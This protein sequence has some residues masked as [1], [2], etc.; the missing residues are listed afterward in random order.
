MKNVNPVAKFILKENV[1]LPLAAR[2]D[3]AI[4]NL[5]ACAQNSIAA[6]ADFAQAKIDLSSVLKAAAQKGIGVFRAVQAYAY[7][8]AQ[9]YDATFGTWLLPN[10]NG[11]IQ[12]KT[13]VST[14]QCAYRVRSEFFPSTEK[15]KRG[16]MHKGA[17]AESKAIQDAAKTSAN[18]T[19][20][21]V[22]ADSLACV[23]ANAEAALPPTR[24]LQFQKLTGEIARYVQ[25]RSG[26]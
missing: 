11:S 22:F 20:E 10:K 13:Y 16:A 26:K 4:A 23:L 21:G 3:A 15:G 25:D 24:W 5:G 17:K 7:A 19:V 12:G 9:A 8:Q 1:A 6:S 2:V 14:K 18:E